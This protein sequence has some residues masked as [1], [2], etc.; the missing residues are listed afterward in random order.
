MGLF[1]SATGLI[2]VGITVVMIT[3]KVARSAMSDR[4]Q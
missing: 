4:E 2:L 1:E 3:V